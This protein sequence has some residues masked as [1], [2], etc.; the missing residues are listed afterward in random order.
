MSAS[1]SSDTLSEQ[2]SLALQALQPLQ[3]QQAAPSVTAELDFAVRFPRMAVAYSGGLDSAVLLHLAQQFARDHGVVLLA[4]HIHHGLSRNADQWQ[5]HCREQC[6]QLDVDFDTCNIA[7]DD[8][9]KSGIEEAARIARYRALGQLCRQHDVGLLL[10]AHHLDDQAETVL[11]QLL[12]G[13]GVAGMSGMDSAHS[14]A[15]LLDNT[16]LLLARPL[17]AVARTAL[18]AHASACQIAFVEDESNHDTR[19]ARNALRHHVMPVLGEFFPGYQTRFARAASHAQAAQRLLNGLAAQDLAVC[20]EGDCLSLPLLRLLDQDRLDNLLRY[21]FAVRGLRMPSAAW[22]AELRAQ[23]LGAKEDAQLCVTHPDCHIRRY[24]ERVFLTPREPAFDA[25]AGPQQ[26][27]WKGERSLHFPRFAGSLLFDIAQYGWAPQWLREQTLILTLRSGGERL[28]L[29]ANR[30]AK[31]LK[32]HYQ[33]RDIP[34]WERPYLP[35]VFAGGQ[36]LYAAGIGMDCHAQ[37]A[38]DDTSMLRIVLRW[39]AD[40]G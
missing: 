33:A 9:E 10:T 28:K 37:S 20:L 23:L 7:L 36:L 38:A 25:D 31:S 22:L 24:R 29:A 2:L 34:A 15:S 3:P 4:F 40:P 19:Y 39:Q 6:A 1:A 14:A 12:R 35:I 8:S 32:Y 5:Q 16:H 30:P 17:L 11:L 21:W 13:A 27:V 26:F 18:E